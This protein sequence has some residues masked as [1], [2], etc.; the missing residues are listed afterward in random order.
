MEDRERRMW[1]KQLQLQKQ[2]VELYKERCSLLKEQNDIQKQLIERYKDHGSL[3][4]EQN[5]ILRQMA[6]VEPRKE[7]SNG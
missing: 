4:K 5:D 6:G 1:E 2:L 7:N 3:L